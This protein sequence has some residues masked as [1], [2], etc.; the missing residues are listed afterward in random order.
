MIKQLMSS[1]RFAPLF[2]AQFCSALNDNVLKNALV[3][4]LLYGAVATHGDAL[5]TVAGAVFIFPFFILSGLGGEIADKY[6]KGV[7][8]RRLKFAEIFAAVFAALGFFMHSV[9]LLFVALALFGVVAALFGPVKYAMLPDQLTVGELATGNALVEGATFM[10]ILIGTIAG[11]QLVSETT[12]MGLVSLAVV[13]LAL[14]SWGSAS[15]IPHTAPSAPE[16]RINTNP[17]TST[18]HLLKSL[19]A[20]PRLWDGMIIVSW[21]WLAGAVVLSLLPALVKGVV[22]GTEGVV[23][24]CLAVFAIGIA[25]GSL[26][27]AQLSH[28]RPNLALVPIGAIVMG[29]IGLD[30]AWAIG[31]TTTGTDI[32]PSEFI[33]SWAGVHLL[34]DFALFA[35]GGGLF[36]VPSFAAVQ[37]WSAPSERRLPSW[38]LARWA[39]PACR[40]RGFPWLGSSSAS[41]S[42]ASAL[43]GSCSINGV[44]KACAISAGCCSARCSAPRCA[45][46]KTCRRSAPAC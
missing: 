27:A 32:T 14:L 40:R 4:M 11:G 46:W 2:W 16:L 17:W 5:V 3:I 7:V 8:A 12:H 10:A 15:R 6:V 42:Q 45:G 19:Y 18:A 29:V 1:R 33:T 25:V 31:T 41:R 20:E 23:T 35:F 26:F 13:G 38:S 39:S 28:V 9:P 22:G 30:L 34:V 21:F 24:L 44:A 43:S 37:A 36:V